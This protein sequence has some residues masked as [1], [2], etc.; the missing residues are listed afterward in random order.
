MMYTNTLS[1][2]LCGKYFDDVIDSSLLVNCWH[3]I[4]MSTCNI[5]HCVCNLINAYCLLSLVIQ[6]SF[7]MTCS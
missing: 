1:Q 2:S 6:C 4:V 5:K 3:F 7:E